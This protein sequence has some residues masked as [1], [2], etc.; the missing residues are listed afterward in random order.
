M[1]LDQLRKEWEANQAS[2]S[3]HSSA[4]KQ[5]KEALTSISL[6]SKSSSFT[7]E[8]ILAPAEDRAPPS[9]DT[10]MRAA[11]SPPSSPPTSSPPSPGSKTNPTQAHVSFS[12]SSPNN[13]TF[14]FPSA[15]KVSPLNST[16]GSNNIFM[17]T[18]NNNIYS[19]NTDG[20]NL[21]EK[22]TKIPGNYE[23]RTGNTD[24]NDD[25]GHTL[26]NNTENTPE[27]PIKLEN[28][29]ISEQEGVPEPPHRKVCKTETEIEA[30]N[31]N[32]E[33]MR[34]QDIFQYLKSN[35]TLLAEEWHK[36]W[37]SDRLPTWL[38]VS[39]LAATLHTQS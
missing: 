26:Q 15:P 22:F 35:S 3:S 29:K 10:L 5:S 19:N 37:Q 13:T 14:H 18:N 39:P 24:S 33:L 1:S 30:A 16:F 34:H 23:S 11:P 20:I 12:S 38:N 27:Y 32:E 36:R 21:H 25:S 2:K 9:P 4:G 8:R 28:H 31:H 7:I 17:N 6:P